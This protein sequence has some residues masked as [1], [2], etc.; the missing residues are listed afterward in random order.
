M[1]DTRRKKILAFVC[2]VTAGV[3]ANFMPFTLHFRVDF[4]FGGIFALIALYMLPP[5]AGIISAALISLPTFYLWNHSLG[6][7]MYTAEGVL[8]TLLLRKTRLHLLMCAAITW[9]FILPPLIYTNMQLSG[10]F[11]PAAT[12]LFL[13]KYMI[14]GIFNAA[15]A[16]AILFFFK[17]KAP[18]ERDNEMTIGASEAAINVFIIV[19]VIPLLVFT[20]LDSRIISGSVFSQI[21]THHDDLKKALSLQ[22]KIWHDHHVSLVRHVADHAGNSNINYDIHTLIEAQCRNRGSLRY[23]HVVDLQGNIIAC[24]PKHCADK[25][26]CKKHEQVLQSY[27]KTVVDTGKPL[28]SGIH[29]AEG[30]TGESV[31]VIAEPI[32]KN[33]VLSGVAAGGLDPLSIENSLA[34]L[35]D[36]NIS[37]KI[38]DLHNKVVYAKNLSEIGHPYVN[39][40]SRAMSHGWQIDYHTTRRRSD[41]LLPFPQFQNHSR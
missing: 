8:I 19:T 28:T 36:E 37:V 10:L 41:S 12:R 15:V 40:L 29:R 6:I 26:M 13:L 31:I 16:S 4:L 7:I 30:N 33:G 9:F 2:L 20:L 14:N 17:L 18:G 32:L 21:Q 35:V 3:V 23:L 5:V 38:V 25:E 34:A 11:F 24:C 39:Q 22:I 1:V 27:N